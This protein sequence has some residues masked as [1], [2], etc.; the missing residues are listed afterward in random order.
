MELVKT[1]YTFTIKNKNGDVLLP[2]EKFEPGGEI[3]KV[4][5]ELSGLLN[6]KVN[7]LYDAT[8]KKIEVINGASKVVAVSSTT[9]NAKADA[10]KIIRQFEKEFSEDCPDAEGM[11][12]I[13]H[14]LLRPRKDDF[15]L[16]TVCLDKDCEFCGEEDPYSFRASVFLPYWPEAFSVNF[17]NYFEQMIRTE[18][19][20]HVM[21]KVCWLNNT[22]MREL[23]IIYKGWISALAEHSFDTTDK[24]KFLQFKSANDALVRLLPTLHT[25]Y[26]EATLHDCDESEDPNPVMLGKTI[27]GT[28]KHTHHE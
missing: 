23:E 18:S 1:Y 9:Y 13:E 12:L 3:E 6:D 4:V 25:V 27:L 16:M 17:R 20:A 11:M 26:P 5:A 7:Y 22:Q 14:I 19:P 15:E 28:I 21:L 10:D 24:N 8:S 2:N